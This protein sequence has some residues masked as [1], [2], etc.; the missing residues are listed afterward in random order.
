M[1]K[2]VK[3]NSKSNKKIYIII[4]VILCI[5]IFI[6]GL[7]KIIG[8]KIEND[9]EQSIPKYIKKLN[10]GTYKLDNTKKSIIS[11]ETLSNYEVINDRYR[12]IGYVVVTPKN[13]KIKYKAYI[14]YCIYKTRGYNSKTKEVINS[15]HTLYIFKSND[16]ITSSI[17]NDL[18]NENSQLIYKY[19][20]KS[21][22]CELDTSLLDGYDINNYIFIYDNEFVAYNYETKKIYKTGIKRK[23]VTLEIDNNKN[24]VGIYDTISNFYSIKYKKLIKIKKNEKIIDYDDYYENMIVKNVN[25]DEKTVINIKTGKRSNDYEYFVNGSGLKIISNKQKKYN[26]ADE[27]GNPVFKEDCTYFDY[28]YKYNNKIIAHYTNKYAIYDLETK[29]VDEHTLDH[30][31]SKMI[32]NYIL[33]YDESNSNIIIY[34]LNGDIIKEIKYV[35]PD[36]GIQ[37]FDIFRG[38]TDNVPRKGEIYLTLINKD[39]SKNQIE[40]DLYMLNGNNLELV[41][42]NNYCGY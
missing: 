32:D 24:L 21:E 20:C 34:N 42:G 40:C 33:C 36:Y 23:F 30:K 35:L 18:E 5:V 11:T 9:I 3:E 14:K 25:S 16:K 38:E 1:E 41:K 29:K 4:I 7:S 12:N 31:I 15:I 6:L 39:K 28:I 8:M 26:Y 27:Y 37:S 19:N 22:L 2:G 13:G 17:Y 10:G